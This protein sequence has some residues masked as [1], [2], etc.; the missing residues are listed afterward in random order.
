[1]ATRRKKIGSDPRALIAGAGVTVAG[2]AAAT[3]WWLSRPSTQA[4][5][6]ET[7]RVRQAAQNAVMLSTK[8][9]HQPFASTNPGV[10]LYLPTGF[11]TDLPTDVVFYWRGFGSCIKVIAG[12]RDDR[13]YPGGNVHHHSS[14]VSQFAATRKNALLIVPETL[15]E[16]AS[17]D[18]GAF[19]REGGFAAF[20]QE[21]LQM[22]GSHVQTP[23]QP[24]RSYSVHSHSG[25]WHANAE[26]LKRSPLV[27]DCSLLDS[28]YGDAET[29]EAYAMDAARVGFPAKRFVSIHTGNDPTTHTMALARK[30]RAQFPNAVL[31]QGSDGTPTIADF[32]HPV[33]VKT[34]VINHSDVPL[35]YFGKILA[36]SY[37]ETLV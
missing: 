9:A 31:I 5:N 22:M 12:D 36:S 35:F 19:G 11:R 27:R 14:I 6:S 33:F 1:M 3:A 32:Q 13:C 8:L 28:F 34:S 21:A 30:V 29:F 2:V 17:T 20:M 26:I 18:L 10:I 16:S 25:G 23:L 4:A 7:P 37:L 15:V 24:I